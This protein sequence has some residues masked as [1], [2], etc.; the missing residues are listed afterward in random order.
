MKQITL[1][2]YEASFNNVKNRIIPTRTKTGERIHT[3]YERTVMDNSS[4]PT[5]Q[6]TIKS[7]EREKKMKEAELKCLGERLI[8][9]QKEYNEKTVP[10]GEEELEVKKT[11]AQKAKEL[12]ETV[13]QNTGELPQLK[14]APKETPKYYKDVLEILFLD[15]LILISQLTIFRQSLSVEQLFA[16]T[17]MI[18]GISVFSLFIKIHF[19]KTG[20]IVHKIFYFICI[21]MIISAV[22]ATIAIDLLFPINEIVTEDLFSLNPVVE[23]QQDPTFINIY[24]QIPGVM[25]LLVTVF[26]FLL[27]GGIMMKSNKE[28][29]QS[30]KSNAEAPKKENFISRLEAE[31]K[32]CDDEVEKCKKN[33]E[34]EANKYT[35]KI[36]VMNDNILSCRER[37][38]NLIDLISKAKSDFKIEYD[39]LM[40]S[41]LE[42]ESC[43]V[44]MMAIEFEISPYD[45][46]FES[47]TQE[48]I[49]QYLNI[50]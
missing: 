12:L 20:E 49:Y 4:L 21:F 3:N 24:R 47:M 26:L 1:N 32:R 17:M 36:N 29:S 50:I 25:E 22:F 11:K 35:A 15:T 45:V 39:T 2:V 19:K 5:H 8:T 46:Q 30:G 9:T 27:S 41:I 10:A 34:D 38:D 44:N 7:H 23:E 6:K 43:F 33:I 37:I 31:V 13:I 14:K 16:R 42:Y 18:I 40:E 48:D 28:N